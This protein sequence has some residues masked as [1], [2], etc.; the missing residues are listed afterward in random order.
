M[1]SRIL[2]LALMGAALAATVFAG[3]ASL[4]GF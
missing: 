2:R 4:S 3:G 1:I